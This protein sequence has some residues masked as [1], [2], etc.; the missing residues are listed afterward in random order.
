MNKDSSSLAKEEKQPEKDDELFPELNE[1]M[2]KYPR[3][4]ESRARLQ[5][6][7]APKQ[8]SFYLQIAYN[9]GLGKEW[10]VVNEIFK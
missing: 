3:D 5:I 1:L 10:E 2:K 6:S 4:P 7:Y 8:F 9:P